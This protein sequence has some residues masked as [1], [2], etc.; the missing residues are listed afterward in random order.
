MNTNKHNEVIK[1]LQ[2]F[3]T[4][5]NIFQVKE[6]VPVGI[7]LLPGNGKLYIE[8]STGYGDI[9]YNNLDEV[10]QEIE[11]HLDFI[12]VPNY[13]KGDWEMFIDDE[14]FPAD[15]ISKSVVIVRSSKEAIDFCNAVQSFPKNIMFDH[16]LGGADTS[17]KFI[18]W[19]IDRLYIDEPRVF[20]LREDFTFSVHSQN[21]IGA[22]NITATMNNII[23]DQRNTSNGN[24]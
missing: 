20:K 17:M 8:Y 9:L 24:T 3:I 19:M 1:R 10:L 21:P 13:A 16:D 7:K 5:N 23:K 18:N 12:N 2:I 14:R 4:S 11:K 15:S 6:R 22:A